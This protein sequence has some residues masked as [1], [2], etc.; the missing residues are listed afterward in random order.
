M[1]TDL[2]AYL[3]ADLEASALTPRRRETIY[4]QPSQLGGPAP[5]PA[6]WESC[7]LRADRGVIVYA[8]QMLFSAALIALCSV[9]LFEADGDCSKSSPYISLLSFLAGK[10]LASI[11]NSSS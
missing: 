4:A 2:P 5:R 6:R 10:V 1:P 11:V 9:M 7:C 8:G 3:P